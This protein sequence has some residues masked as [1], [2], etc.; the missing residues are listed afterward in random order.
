MKIS[1]ACSQGV[2]VGSHGVRLKRYLRSIGY[3][4][5]HQ[6]KKDLSKTLS[7]LDYKIRERER[8]RIERK[9]LSFW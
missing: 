4:P 3:S 5:G 7:Y 6:C 2:W 9:Q 8:I 1:A